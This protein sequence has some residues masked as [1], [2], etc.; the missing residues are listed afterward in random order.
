MSRFTLPWG[1]TV[2][3]LALLLITVGSGGCMARGGKSSA[4]VEARTT[5]AGQELKDLDA[6]REKGL[7]SDREY[8]RM[9]REIVRRESGSGCGGTGLEAAPLLLWML[10][11]KRRAQRPAD[12][13]ASPCSA[14]P[15]RRDDG[16]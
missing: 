10:W 16:G 2:A 4:S 5:T 1:T 3:S 9:R 13:E 7:I 11:R 8:E 14:R 15:S 6:A 12:S